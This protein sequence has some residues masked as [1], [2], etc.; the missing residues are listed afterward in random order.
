MSEYKILLVGNTAVGKSSLIQRC[1]SG[2]CP[3]RYVP[4]LG[5]IQSQLYFRNQSDQQVIFNVSELG[6]FE[7]FENPNPEHYLGAHGA[8]VMADCNLGSSIDY[9]SG[10]IQRVRQ[11]N[12]NIPVC[13]LLNRPNSMNINQRIYL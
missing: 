12:P 5:L 6:G 10:W 11:F 8:I 13:C 9:V 2:Q 3:K 7:N 1:V 4:T